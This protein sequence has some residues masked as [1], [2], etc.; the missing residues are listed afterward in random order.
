MYL[1]ITWSTN[2]IYFFLFSQANPNQKVT[3]R[4]FVLIITALSPCF[5]ENI[6]S[7]NRTILQITLSNSNKKKFFCDCA[8][9]LFLILNCS[10]GITL[11]FT[12]TLLMSS[13]NSPKQ[14][15][16]GP[17]YLELGAQNKFWRVPANKGKKLVLD[18]T[19]WI[20]T[21]VGM[22]HWRVGVFQFQWNTLKLFSL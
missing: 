3:R 13:F 14:S 18:V 21:K 19:L 16:Q 9:S 5:P 7:N 22:Q 4:N 8:F 15:F 6:S 20:F 2:T 12:D 17:L 11:C 10:F 1:S